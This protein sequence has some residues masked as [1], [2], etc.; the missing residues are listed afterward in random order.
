VCGW[1][2]PARGTTTNAKANTTAWL[3]SRTLL[4][5]WCPASQRTLRGRMTEKHGEM[6]TYWMA[7][8]DISH[9][10][11][12]YHSWWAMFHTKP[13]KEWDYCDSGLQCIWMHIYIHLYIHMQY[14]YVC[15]RLFSRNKDQLATLSGCSCKCSEPRHHGCCVSLGCWRVHNCSMRCACLTCWQVWPLFAPAAEECGAPKKICTAG[16]WAMKRERERGQGTELAVRF[17]KML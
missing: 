14:K 2:V 11:S 17:C 13:G 12:K 4:Q 5:S 15:Q 10:L 8:D 6:D 1:W 9:I 16:G 7:N 3:S